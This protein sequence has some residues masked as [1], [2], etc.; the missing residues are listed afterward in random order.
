MLQQVELQVLTGSFPRSCGLLSPGDSGQQT[1]GDCWVPLAPTATLRKEMG[2]LTRA[3]SGLWHHSL[4]RRQPP[5]VVRPAV[6][7]VPE[8]SGFP[9]LWTFAPEAGVSPRHQG[10]AR[11]L[12]SWLLAE[13]LFAF[14]IKKTTPV[15]NFHLE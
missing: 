12:L 13:D 5:Q 6:G 11:A 3:S 7:Q 14:T 9:V 15:V 2:L 8:L 4:Q 1:A 10:Q